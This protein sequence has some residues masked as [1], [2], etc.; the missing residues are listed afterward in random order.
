MHRLPLHGFRVLELASGQDIAYAGRLLADFGA[1]VITVGAQASSD[2]DLA[3]FLD[4]NKYN[5]SLDHQQKAAET[6]LL[7]LVSLSDVV[8]GDLSD[9]LTKAAR[10]ASPR[11]IHISAKTGECPFN[12]GAALAA[13]AIMALWRLRRSGEGLEVRIDPNGALLHLLGERFLAGEVEAPVTL[14]EMA[15]GQLPS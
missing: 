14:P 6:L 10:E 13:V 4:Y 12:A 2:G 3:R 5:C 11:F 7:Q 8:L 1:E 15:P 9:R